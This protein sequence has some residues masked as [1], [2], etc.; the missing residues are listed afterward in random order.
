MVGVAKSS[1]V[2]RIP[3]VISPT[4]KDLPLAFSRG[5]EFEDKYALLRGVGKVSKHL[6][7]RRAEQVD[8]EVLAYCVRQ[9]VELDSGQ[10]GKVSE[11]VEQSRLGL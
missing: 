1:D 3:A 5:A 4:Q 6:K 11:G 2:N 7:F 8:R 9:A 10:L